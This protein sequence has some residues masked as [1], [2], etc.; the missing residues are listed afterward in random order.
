MITRWPDCCDWTRGIGF[1]REQLRVQVS[2][3][4]PIWVQAVAQFSSQAMATLLSPCQPHVDH[5]DQVW[6]LSVLKPEPAKRFRFTHS[7]KPEPWT[8]G[9]NSGSNQV[10]KVCKPDHSQSSP[11]LLVVT[12]IDNNGTSWF[13]IPDN[14]LGLDL[15]PVH[16]QERGFDYPF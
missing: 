6:V 3:R 1:G 11:E 10:W 15:A 14:W 5:G 12:T 7:I 9:S 8:Q 2:T 4:F 16:F 13:W